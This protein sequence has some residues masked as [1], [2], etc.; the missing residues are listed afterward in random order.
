MFLEG[1]LTL[2]VLEV[3]AFTTLLLLEALGRLQESFF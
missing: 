2:S 1:A 3:S